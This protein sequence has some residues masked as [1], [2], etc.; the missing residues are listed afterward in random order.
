MQLLEGFLILYGILPVIIDILLNP[1]IN[2]I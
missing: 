1:S 2:S